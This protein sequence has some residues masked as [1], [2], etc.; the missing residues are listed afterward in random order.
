MS[1]MLRLLTFELALSNHPII[2][3]KYSAVVLTPHKTSELTFFAGKQI[4]LPLR[5]VGT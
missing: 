3:R 1:E 2:H 4:A 5:V